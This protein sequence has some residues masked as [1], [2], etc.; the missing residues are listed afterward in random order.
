[1]PI[2]SAADHAF[3]AGNGY[4]VV[5]KAVPPQNLDAAIDAI[6]QFLGMDRNDP[7][8]WY[9]EPH[10]HGGMVE[11]YQHPAL[12]ANRQHPR[13]HQA[14]SEIWD[15]ARLWVSMDR[16]SMKPPP[17]PEHPEYDHAGFIHWDCDTSQRPVPFGVQG[18]LYLADTEADQGGFQCVPELFRRFEE[19]V[20]TQPADRHPRFPDLAGFEVS[21]IPGK[22]GD[23]LIWHRLLP[24]GNGRN[25]SARPRL[26]QYI[27]MY[28]AREDNEELRQKRI[29]MWRD[30]LPPGGDAFPGDPR[31]WEQQYGQTAELSPLGRKLLGL[32]LWEDEP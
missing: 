10:R 7:A 2:L 11:L 25:L 30:R 29:R 13:V 31:G 9:R 12:W 20:E 23:L 27:T 8:D 22:A 15:T 5:P 6:W 14:F 26:A 18:V 28:P 24:H 21:P 4:V 1:M 3:F 17:H 19:W 32:D 16:V